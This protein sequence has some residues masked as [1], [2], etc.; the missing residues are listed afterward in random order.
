MIS[1]F[2]NALVLSPHPDDAEFSCGGT[3]NKMNREGVKVHLVTFSPC[4]KSLP[5][6]LD[7]DILYQEQA[8]SV[9]HLGIDKENVVNFNFPVREFPR[10][11]QEILEE[12]IILRKKISPDLVVLPNS[13]DIHQD[14]KTIFEE[15]LRA[16]KNC[17]LIG[18]E[19]PWNNIKHEINL[20]VE[21]DACD[22]DA[23]LKSI[24]EY[25]SQSHR[26]Y[27]DK[28]FFRGLASVRGVMIGA[29]YAEGFQIINWKI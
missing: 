19:L 25:K 8:R 15:G 2:Q 17:C 4:I 24:G 12:L 3:L 10:Y 13:N 28:D 27:M 7:P 5:D 11:R 29:K 18:Y 22:L 20:R 26:P 23:K 16:F 14:H 9:E 6:G 21:L 1:T